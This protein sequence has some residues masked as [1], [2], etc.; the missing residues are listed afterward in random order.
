[1]KHIAFVCAALL[2]VHAGA[3][4]AQGGCPA[5]T[6]LVRETET[7]WHCITVA[8]PTIGPGFFVS[9]A[10][11]QFAREQIAALNIKKRRYEGQLVA[12]SRVRDG[13]EVAARDLNAVRREIVFDN[14][15]H[16]LNVIAWAAGDTLSGALKAAVQQQINVLKAEVNTLA[17]TDAQPLSDRQFQKSIDALFNLKNL[18]LDNASSMPPEQLQAFKRASDTLPK[19]LRISE[20]FSQPNPGADTVKQVADTLDDLASATAEFIPIL[21]ATRSTVHMVGGEIAL[22]HIERS[23]A[24]IDDAFVSSQ[25]AKRYYLQRIAE[26]NE[27]QATWRERIQ[28]AGVK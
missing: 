25:T 18:I 2:A 16:A 11:V 22:W 28:R 27:A 24:Q 9:E 20:R 7:A 26:N 13:L 14:M 17:A 5:G 23:K 21:K 6:Q 3:A 19:L 8:L 1:M 12:L 15:S 4:L 10:E